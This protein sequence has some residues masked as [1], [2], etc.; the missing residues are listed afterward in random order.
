MSPGETP[1]SQMTSRPFEFEE[2]GSR[3][4]VRVD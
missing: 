2:W 4:V 3:E 1:R